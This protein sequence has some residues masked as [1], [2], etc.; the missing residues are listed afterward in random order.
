MIFK[1]IIAILQDVEAIGKNK[2]NTMQNYKFRG[3]DDMYNAL[4]PLFSKHGVFIT[5]EVLS[6]EREE[7]TTAK[8]GL[9][10]YT[11]L[12]VKFN[13]FAEDGSN[14]SS[15]LRGEAMDSGDKATNK[16]ESTA[17]KYAL[18]QMFLIP[19]DEKLDTEYESPEPVAKKEYP[20]DNRPWL[21]EKLLK[22]VIAR[23]KSGDIE[24][25]EKALNH[26]KMKTDYKKQ[27]QEA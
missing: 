6:A 5:S 3:I 19:T 18:M 15:T 2:T 11:I 12:N 21:T 22:E 8:G 1:K 7:R 13:F 23:I 14:V 24:A 26:F 27:I 17:L 10:L 25:K 16:A 9:L 4:H 20:E